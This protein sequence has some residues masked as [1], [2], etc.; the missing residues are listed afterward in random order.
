M[1]LI[2]GKAKK[3]KTFVMKSKTL[4]SKFKAFKALI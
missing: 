3:I 4:Y 1:N 2:L